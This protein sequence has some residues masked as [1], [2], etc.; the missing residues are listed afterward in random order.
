LKDFRPQTGSLHVNTRTDTPTHDNTFV[1][2][3]LKG[4]SYHLPMEFTCSKSLDSDGKYHV[5]AD[6]VLIGHIKQE[7]FAENKKAWVWRTLAVTVHNN[8][9][10]VSDSLDG[11]KADLKASNPVLIER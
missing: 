4:I 9:S 1:Y 10:G 5:K 2:F 3:A 11:A 8:R 7:G 6:G